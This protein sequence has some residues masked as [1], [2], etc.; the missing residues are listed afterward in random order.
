MYRHVL[1]AAILLFVS[2]IALAAVE[3]GPQGLT[4]RLQQ[5]VERD[6][7]RVRD[8][9]NRG[10][11]E[12]RRLGQENGLGTTE[13]RRALGEL[14]SRFQAAR[15]QW[16]DSGAAH[17]A[18]AD[19]RFERQLRTLSRQTLKLLDRVRRE[20]ELELAALRVRSNLPARTQRT[21]SVSAGGISG[22]V[23]A[24]SDST[25]LEAIQVIAFDENDSW[26]DLVNTDNTGYYEFPDLEDGT[27]FLKTY[28]YSGYIDKLYK[29]IECPGGGTW[30]DCDHCSGTPVV[31]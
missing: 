27:Y 17:Q 4:P 15:K 6:L 2:S 13:F 8:V 12:A 7:G 19:T 30:G 28:N 20:S 25:P 21:A 22:M 9:V 26:V 5:E 24:A 29:N 10:D 11:R 31:I 1:F 23:R 18:S 14:Q 3:A 16:Q